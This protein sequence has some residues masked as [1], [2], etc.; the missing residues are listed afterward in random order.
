MPDVRMDEIPAPE[1]LEL[2]ARR[3]LGRL[4]FIHVVS[5]R[6]MITPVNYLLHGGS[7]TFRT[8]AGSKLSAAVRGGAVAF[9]VDGLDEPRRL[10]WSV[11]VLGH[12]EHVTDTADLA[13][14][15]QSS[16]IPWA[17]GAKPNYVRIKTD[18]VQG[19]RVRV[20]ELPFNWW[21]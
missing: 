15:Q 1:S 19:R 6:P 12:A 21:G 16:L 5:S 9:E 4:A 17:P 14:L 3:S 13:T 10:G 18:D 2:L 11:V 8:D 20:D 7:V